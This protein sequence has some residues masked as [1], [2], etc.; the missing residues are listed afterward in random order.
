MRNRVFNARNFFAAARDP[1]KQNQYGGTVGGPIKKDSSFI[2]FG[3]QGTR[4]RTQNN[5]SRPQP[6]ELRARGARP[7]SP[8]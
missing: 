4:L 3:Y 1:L 2:F 5:A 8:G 6:L 7:A